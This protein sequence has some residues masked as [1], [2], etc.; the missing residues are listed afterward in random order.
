[1]RMVA[2]IFLI[3]TA[4]VCLGQTIRRERGLVGYFDMENNVS[5][6]VVGGMNGTKYGTGTLY[7]NRYASKGTYGFYCNSGRYILTGETNILAGAQEY[8]VFIR[9]WRIIFRDRAGLVFANAQIGLQYPYLGLCDGDTAG[10]SNAVHTWRGVNT[11]QSRWLSPYLAGGWQTHFAQWSGSQKKG[12]YTLDGKMWSSDSPTIAVAFTNLTAFGL[13]VDTRDVTFRALAGYIDDVMI[14]NRMLAKP[15]I[16]ALI[17]NKPLPIAGN[18]CSLR[19][20]F[21]QHDGRNSQM[22]SPSTNN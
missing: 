21:S 18:N 22:F 14:F 12:L 1:M 15:E 3:G 11:E 20:R 4:V 16:E 8:A 13:G 5:N 7:T 17:Y 10:H 6:R 19:N 9:A 2:A